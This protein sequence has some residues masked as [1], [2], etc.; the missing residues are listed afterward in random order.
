MEVLHI[1]PNS[2]GY[3]IVT[4]EANKVSRKNQMK[5]ISKDGQEYMTGGFILNDTPEI[6]SFLDSFPVEKQYDIVKSIKVDPFV[7]LYLSED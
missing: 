4:L 5:A 2:K 3:E 1:T 6:R 7:K